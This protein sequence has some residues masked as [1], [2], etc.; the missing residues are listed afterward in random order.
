[1]ENSD[2]TLACGRGKYYENGIFRFAGVETSLTADSPSARVVS[3]YREVA[4]NAAFYGLMRREVA[5]AIPLR[6]TL[7][8][9]WFFVAGTAYLGKIAVVDDVSIH[10]SVLGASKDIK[11]LALRAGLGKVAA[12]D[13]L[14]VIAAAICKDIA[15]RSPTYRQL[16]V[17]S[18]IM[19]G[20]K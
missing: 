17:A 15:W 12:K 4:F 7:A 8:A 19:L 9:D 13:P 10:R 3:F 14:L 2:F 11:E 1:I 6:D 5:S 18:R 16:G 20:T